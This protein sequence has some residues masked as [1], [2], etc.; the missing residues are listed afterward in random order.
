L[1]FAVNVI[2]LDR[3][4]AAPSLIYLERKRASSDANRFYI[5]SS[6]RKPIIEKARERGEGSNQ[7]PFFSNIIKCCGPRDRIRDVFIDRT[8]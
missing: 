2:S 5:F 6:S 1:A 3:L 4:S 8:S 7:I